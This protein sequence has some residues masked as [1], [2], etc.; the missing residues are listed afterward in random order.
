[1]LRSLL[2]LNGVLP[3]LQWFEQVRSLTCVAAD[4]AGRRLLDLA[5]RPD[6][7]VGDGDSFQSNSKNL[8]CEFIFNPDQNTTDF[9][10]CLKEIEKRKLFPTLVCGIGGGEIDHQ[11]HSL[12]VFV[13]YAKKYPMLFVDMQEAFKAKLGLAVKDKLVFQNTQEAH[14]SLL[15][16]PKARLTSRGLV[17]PLKD[18]VLSLLKRSGARN[19]TQG[20]EVK[21]IKTSGDILVVVDLNALNELKMTGLSMNAQELLQIQCRIPF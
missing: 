19:R 18:E 10:K 1:M 21:I 7:I 13:R 8:E 4:G 12:S 20:S 5:Y 11:H 14:V 17:W 6:L 3:P 15:P 16:F 2:V 9:E